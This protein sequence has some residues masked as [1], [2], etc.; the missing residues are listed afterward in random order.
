MTSR[1]RNLHAPFEL[2]VTFFLDSPLEPGTHRIADTSGVLD[3]DEISMSYFCFEVLAG[4]VSVSGTLE[5]H[6][7]SE[8][9][10]R[11]S[12]DIEWGVA[13]SRLRGDFDVPIR[14]HQTW[15][16]KLLGY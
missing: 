16:S 1:D 8:A 3:D 2:V 4:S 9:R 7:A 6:E 11:G 15:G 5:I 10:V 12:Y 13:Y 14:Y